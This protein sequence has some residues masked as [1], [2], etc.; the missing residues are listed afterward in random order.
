MKKLLNFTSLILVLSFIFCSCA[1]TDN[2]ETTT[3]TQ[4]EAVSTYKHDL[5]IADLK[6]CLNLSDF[7]ACI[8][9]NTNEQSDINRTVE[10]YGMINVNQTDTEVKDF[11]TSKF[12]EINLYYGED[13]ILSSNSYSVGTQTNE[14][15]S[16]LIKF[17]LNIEELDISYGEY[18]IDRIEFVSDNEKTEY[19][20]S[21]Y[22]NVYSEEQNLVKIIESPTAP[23]MSLNTGEELTVCYYFLTA[24]D[25]F[26]KDFE[27]KTLLPDELAQYIKI[28]DLQIYEDS[29]MLN[30]VA[31]ALSNEMTAQQRENLKVY[32][33]E[34]TYLRLTDKHIVISPVFKLDITGSEQSMGSICALYLQ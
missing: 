20:V 24:N 12:D 32:A 16:Y 21:Y 10:I 25:S 4:T 29:N 9:Y 27:L 34:I 18:K 8:P 15:K 26:N 33:V 11:F 5:Y 13:C 7:V 3:D 1:K 6:S 14:D 22:L 31:D 28:Q 17:S 30:S 23:Y 19:T 2:S